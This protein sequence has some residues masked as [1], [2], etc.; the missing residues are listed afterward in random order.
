M[1]ID[2]NL[3]LDDMS[4]VSIEVRQLSDHYC[5]GACLRIK[6]GD[7]ALR[8]FTDWLEGMDD[9]RKAIEMATQA[10]RIRLERVKEGADD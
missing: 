1:S 6:A 8:L 5:S 10:E 9:L 2:I 4:D 3:H 7:I